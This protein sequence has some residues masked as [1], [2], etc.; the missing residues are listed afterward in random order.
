MPEY[1]LTAATVPTSACYPATPQEL[2]NSLAQYLTVQIDGYNQIYIVDDA[3][4]SGSD[5]NKPWFETAS[6]ANPSEYGLPKVIRVYSGGQWKEFAQFQQGDMI[7]VPLNYP[8][9]APW[10]V[11]GTTYVFGSTGVPNYTVAATPTPPEDYKY[12]V[13]VGYWSSTL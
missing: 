2:I 9:V 12:K 3:V 8:I 7:I 13:Y 1:P 5:Q 11:A 10:G 4:P 6:S